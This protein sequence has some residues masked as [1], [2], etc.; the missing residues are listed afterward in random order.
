M[1]V[2]SANELAARIMAIRGPKKA[3]DLSAHIRG[4]INDYLAHAIARFLGKPPKSVDEA[5][6]WTRDYDQ[7]VAFVQYVME[8]R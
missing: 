7:L 3:E 6:K 8:Q 2:Y 4:E 5:M 1:P